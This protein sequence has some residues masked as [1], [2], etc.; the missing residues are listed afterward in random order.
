MCG[1]SDGYLE[2][3]S[4]LLGTVLVYVGSEVSV[5]EG[6]TEKK[7]AA[8]DTFRYLTSEK[9]TNFEHKECHPFFLLR[10]KKTTT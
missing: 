8:F 4:W 1:G 7:Y 6:G 2:H 3:A 10:G 9:E 5:C